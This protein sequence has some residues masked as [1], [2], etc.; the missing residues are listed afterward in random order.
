MNDIMIVTGGK[1]R[2]FYTSER[3]KYSQDALVV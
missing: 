3:I 2:K 1:V